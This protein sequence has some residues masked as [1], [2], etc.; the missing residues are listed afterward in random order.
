MQLLNPIMGIWVSF[1]QYR[2]RKIQCLLDIQKPQVGAFSFEENI[3]YFICKENNFSEL[4]L[5]VS[6]LSLFSCA[7]R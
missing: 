6:H 2:Y 7:T 4:D 1:H 5:N 3:F